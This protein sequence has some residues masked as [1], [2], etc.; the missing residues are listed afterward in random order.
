MVR[1]RRGPTSIVLST[2]AHSQLC[3]PSIRRL[4]AHVLLLSVVQAMINGVVIGE[5]DSNPVTPFTTF[6]IQ[7]VGVETMTFTTVGLIE[8]DW[9]SLFEASDLPRR[10]PQGKQFC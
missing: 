1:L 6:G 3:H 5:F 8:R 10:R 4:R 9:I 7:G 2:L